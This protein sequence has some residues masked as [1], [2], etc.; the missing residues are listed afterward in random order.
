M[1]FDKTS[2]KDDITLTDEISPYSVYEVSECLL[3]L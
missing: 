3:P 1:M 2:D